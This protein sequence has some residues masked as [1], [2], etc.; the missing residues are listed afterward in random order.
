MAAALSTQPPHL[1]QT[2][3]KETDLFDRVSMGTGLN[4]VRGNDRTES[5]LLAHGEDGFEINSPPRSRFE[6]YSY[7]RPPLGYGGYY[8]YLAPDKERPI[9][10]EDAAASG[11]RGSGSVLSAWGIVGILLFVIA[12]GTLIYYTVICYPCNDVT[13]KYELNRLNAKYN[14]PLLTKLPCG[15]PVQSVIMLAYTH[16]NTSTPSEG[17]P[18]DFT[19]PAIEAPPTTKKKSS[20]LT[21]P[22]SGCSN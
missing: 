6:N 8:R 7:N 14:G 15:R 19:P 21:Q 13:N 1:R 20:N 16:K 12:V 22:V 3:Q 2:I 5:F 17:G 10:G 9:G 11:Y 4:P 18:A